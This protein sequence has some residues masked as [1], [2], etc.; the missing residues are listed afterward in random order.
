MGKPFLK[1]IKILLSYG[2][3]FIFPP[4]CFVCE[5]RNDQAFPLCKNCLSQLIASSEVTVHKNQSDFYHL[6]DTLF[7]DQ[8][9]TLWPY[10]KIIESLIH[11]MKYNDR[12]KL[13]IFLGRIAGKL[14]HQPLKI[15]GREVIIP[16]PLH[17][18]RYRERGYNQST[19]LARGLSQY[20]QLSIYEDTLF[21]IKPT[22]SQTTLSAEQRCSNLKN[23]F[24]VLHPE[25]IHHK[26]VF[27][28]DDVSTTGAT[29]NSCSFTLQQ[30]GAGEI[31]GLALARP[32]F[33]E[34]KT[35]DK[36]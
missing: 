18:T 19:L 31:I 22:K 25:K 3:D 32:E 14:L 36:G 23:A 20:I 10:I 28:V 34:K 12:K 6:A 30:A 26:K 7:F 24:A 33:E 27:L 17:K 29:F 1:N 4:L 16:V 2:Y 15:T 8:V 21:R 5:K 9:I 35:K 13:G 11:Q